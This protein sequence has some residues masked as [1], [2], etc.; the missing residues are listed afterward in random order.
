MVVV[1][2]PEPV[3]PIDVEA[4]N[5]SRSKT[6][7]TTSTGLY[8]D[9][10]GEGPIVLAE[11]LSSIYLDGKRL[12]EPEGKF[13]LSSKVGIGSVNGTTVTGPT[14]FFDN[15]VPAAGWRYALV[16]Q[17]GAAI[18]SG[19]SAS[20]GATTITTPSSF[21][22]TPDMLSTSAGS[23]G[24]RPK[25][26]IPGAGING[27]DYE[28]III[29]ITS[30]TEAVIEPEIQTAVSNGAIYFDHFSRVDSYDTATDTCTL[31]DS[32]PVTTSNTRI[33]LS[34][35]NSG[36]SNLSIPTYENF[37]DVAVSYRMG[38]RDQKPF[39]TIG[40]FNTAAFGVSIGAEIRQHTDFHTYNGVN[41]QNKFDLYGAEAPAGSITIQASAGTY[42][43]GLGDP[44]IVDEVSFILNAPQLYRFKPQSGAESLIPVDFQVFFHHSN[45]GVNFKK[46]QVFGP[47]DAAIKEAFDDGKSFSYFDSITNPGGAGDPFSGNSGRI[48]G[49]P[50][51]GSGN[52]QKDEADYFFNIPLVP[53]KPFNTFYIEIKRITAVGYGKGDYKDY[54][55]TVYVKSAQA[56]IYD[57]LSYPYTA[58]AAIMVN[59]NEFGGKA[60]K[61]TYDVKRVGVLVPTNY[62]TR[63]EN[64]GLTA[65]YTRNKTT[66]VDSGSYQIWDGTFR[67]DTEDF[68]PDSPNY[69][70]VFT[71]N[72]VWG[73]RDL[74]LNERYGLG[75]FVNKDDIN[76]YSL[77]AL[78]RYCDE[79]VPDGKGG[80]EPRFRA[81]WYITTRTQSYK[82]IKDMCTTFLAIPYWLDGQL[83]LESDRPKEPVYSFSRANVIDG[84]FT[85]EGTGNR[86][87][88][89]QIV[90]S[91]E[92]PDNFYKQTPEIV[93]DTENIIKTG[94]VNREDAVAF[95]CTSQGQARRYGKWKLL[96]AKER[97]EIVT[98]KTAEN[99]A[100]IKPGDIINVQDAG[101]D[102]IRYSGRVSSSS[103]TTSINLDSDVTLSSNT[104]HLSIIYPGGAAY[105]LDD[106]ATINGTTY[107]KGQKI[108]KDASNQ[109]INDEEDTANLVDDSGDPVTAIWSGAGHVQTRQVTTSAGTTSTLTVAAAYDSAPEHEF[110]WALTEEDASG[111][112]V[113]GSAREYSVLAIEEA[114]NTYVISAV[115]YVRSIYAEVEDTY[116]LQP[117]RVITNAKTKRVP[118]IVFYGATISE[119]EDVAGTKSSVKNVTIYWT[120]P[121]EDA[122][123]TDGDATNIPFRD[124]LGYKIHHNIEGIVSPITLSATDTSYVF[125][126]VSPGQY[127]VRLQALGING[128]TSKP[129]IIVFEVPAGVGSPEQKQIQLLTG[130]N[131]D[132]PI[133]IIDNKFVVSNSTYT[134]TNSSGLPVT[135]YEGT[136]DQVEIDPS[137]YNGSSLA[138]GETG[139][140][141]F[142]SGVNTE[143]DTNLVTNPEFTSTSSW[144]VGTAWTI[145]GGVANTT[146]NGD[147][148]QNISLTAGN[149]YRITAN[150]TGGGD[151]AL[152]VGLRG[153]TETNYSLFANPSAAGE[154]HTAFIKAPPGASTLVIQ[155]RNSVVG[156]SPTF[157]VDNVAVKK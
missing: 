12:I 97:K 56:S 138:D 156:N 118:D 48:G 103:T 90:V 73:L 132:S 100:H 81:S 116:D 41:M 45:D 134:L 71:D 148:T 83:Y 47:T 11:G 37:K 143:S 101:R 86:V 123:N 119:E 66:G 94:R 20:L 92:N 153:T 74:L 27:T 13:V 70:G 128:S 59:S 104:Y 17:A 65:K 44:S 89:N 147:L 32:A 129:R 144:N 72:P 111:E 157:T 24:L 151:G 137:N 28:G 22:V 136:G 139:Y 154:T 52:P 142:D 82:V 98:F 130:G 19:F 36:F 10:I 64:D 149:Y 125:E 31:A 33:E 99:A 30:A 150:V 61:R 55:N 93:E 152:Y 108:L 133:N 115:E 51:R 114:E 43:F 84:N 15:L 8:I 80:Q 57:K 106:T 21:F 135:V 75:D 76:D 112:P 79:L 110:V 58:M 145:S 68:N 117:P 4:R 9:A 140:I 120:P 87:R 102:R 121:T 67:G 95:G 42:N 25:I 35:I 26:R 91:W 105:L 77:Y 63:E 40:G 85:Y 113:A 7:A 1:I 39:Q 50:S 122:G 38:T 14:D 107:V 131:F 2:P 124:L 6:K 78:A 18:T 69:Y 3:I 49:K 34:A 155:A 16:H 126:D 88:T 23:L 46:E 96:T 141:V 109:D 29:S 62:I 54:Y 53:F 5:N 127:T 146:T 60:P